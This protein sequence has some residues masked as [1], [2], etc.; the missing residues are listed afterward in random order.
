MIEGL[1]VRA[2]HFPSESYTLQSR[3]GSG[4]NQEINDSK[5]NQNSGSHDLPH[6]FY[7]SVPQIKVQIVVGCS[8]ES[9]YLVLIAESAANL[10]NALFSPVSCFKY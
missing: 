7:F 8:H 1:S 4:H 6:S 9:E 3:R 10:K 5:G 2:D